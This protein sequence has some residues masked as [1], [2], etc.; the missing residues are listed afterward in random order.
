VDAGVDA[1]AEA[2]AA[3]AA[4]A[5]GVDSRRGHHR[6]TTSRSA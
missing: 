6:V 4:A 2:V 3:G 1:A 5:D